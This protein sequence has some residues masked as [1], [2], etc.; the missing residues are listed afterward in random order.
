MGGGRF[1]V[2]ERLMYPRCFCC[3]SIQILK[4]QLHFVLLGIRERTTSDIIVQYRKS[5]KL[6]LQKLQITLVYTSQKESS[7]FS[8]FSFRRMRFSFLGK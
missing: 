2:S 6:Q 1:N 8:T 7:L 4:M 5:Y 3:S